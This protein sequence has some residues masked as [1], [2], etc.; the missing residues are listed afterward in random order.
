MNLLGLENLLG[1][2]TDGWE[3][4]PESVPTKILESL[5]YRLAKKMFLTTKLLEM[6]IQ[7]LRRHMPI[8]ARSTGFE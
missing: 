4:P 7:S 2:L 5:T 3:L 8:K 6:R 1:N